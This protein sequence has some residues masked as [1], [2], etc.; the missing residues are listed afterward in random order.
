M[1][2]YVGM[3]PYQVVKMW[4]NFH[5]SVPPEYH[6]NLLY[7]EPMAAQWAKV[8]VES[9]DRAEFRAV[10]KRKKYAMEEMIESIAFNDEA[11]MMD[12]DSGK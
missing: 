5:P 11:E 9:A 1:M 2:N 7:A 8:K 6:D 12:G 4:E 10:N 3:N